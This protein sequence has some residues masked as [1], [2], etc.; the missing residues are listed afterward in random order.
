VRGADD[1]DEES[2]RE[3]EGIYV[4]RHCRGGGGCNDV[5]EMYTKLD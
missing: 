1:D 5:R 4:E 3:R 2:E